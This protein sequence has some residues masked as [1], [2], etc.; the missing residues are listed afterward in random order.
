MA[1]DMA[2]MI[3]PCRDK[4]SHGTPADSFGSIQLGLRYNEEEFKLIVDVGE[5]RGLNAVGE[6]G[7]ANPYVKIKL[8][9]GNASGNKV[10]G[11]V[12]GKGSR[13]TATVYHSLNPNFGEQ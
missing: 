11:A 3:V 12:K 2:E 13:K 1:D 7:Y 8:K 5:A 10:L 9:P 6:S 4:A